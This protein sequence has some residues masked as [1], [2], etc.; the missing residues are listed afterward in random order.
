MVELLIFKKNSVAKVS[1]QQEL[2]IK[3]TDMDALFAY[4]LNFPLDDFN[5]HVQSQKLDLWLGNYLPALEEPALF[6]LVLSFFL[7]F[8]EFCLL[9]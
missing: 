4:Y 2:S 6:L 7:I 5:R 3:C 8:H 1:I 9:E